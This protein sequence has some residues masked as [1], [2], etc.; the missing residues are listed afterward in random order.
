MEF[1]MNHLPEKVI[2]LDRSG[3]YRGVFALMKKLFML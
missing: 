1:Q 2:Y 3:F